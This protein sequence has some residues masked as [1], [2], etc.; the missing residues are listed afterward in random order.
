M[1]IYLIQYH[2]GLPTMAHK[3]FYSIIYIYKD[4]II[5]FDSKYHQERLTYPLMKG[6]L[7]FFCTA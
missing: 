6:T 2:H 1:Q 3:S 4:R 5:F 7:R